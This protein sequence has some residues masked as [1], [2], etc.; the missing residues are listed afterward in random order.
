MLERLLAQ[1]HQF[2]HL[3]ADIRDRRAMFEVWHQVALT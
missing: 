2:R 3:P 1:T